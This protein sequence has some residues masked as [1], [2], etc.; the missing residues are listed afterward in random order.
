MD[1]FESSVAAVLGN[2]P[3]GTV[4]LAA[5]SGGADST[6]MLAALAA[7]RSK[8][9][10][11]LHCLHV[12]HRIRAAAESRGDAEFV[13]GICKKLDVPCRIVTIRPGKVAAKAKE[14]GI[15]IEAAARIYRRRAWNRE[16][17]RLGAA[18]VLAAHTRDDLLETALMRVLRGSGPGGLAALPQSRGRVLRPLLGFSRADVLEYLEERGIP[19]RT[20]ST[21]RDNRFLRNSIRNQ[22]VPL[23]DDLFPQWKTGLGAMAETQRLTADFLQAEARARVFWKRARGGREFS[24]GA[25]GFF[26]HPPIIREEALFRGIDKLLSRRAAGDD[27]VPVKRSNL[28]RFS[29]G[30]I[31]VLDLGFC[32]L[33]RTDRQVIIS[34]KGPGRHEAGF[35]LLIKEPGLY[36]LK[37]VIVEVLPEFSPETREAGAGVFLTSL[38]LVL[39]RS[40]NED[41]LIKAGRKF[42][43]ADLKGGAGFSL[44]SAVHA[45]GIAAFIGGSP[46]AVIVQ[47]GDRP[48]ADCGLKGSARAGGSAGI[49]YCRVL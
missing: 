2:P 26:S 27:P 4:F 11:V 30:G 37:E 16:A 33:K 17:C 35:S 32:S 18:A 29:G 41:W 38:P 49:Y 28:R 15:G 1:S 9:G 23:L 3:P 10:F 5:V 21:N 6:A 45:S 46:G 44:L 25:E 14:L 31:S 47:T 43:P 39:R 20:D 34:G 42:R 12:D 48:G 19:H 7:L 8:A 36:K 40:F 13:E 22:L 24:T